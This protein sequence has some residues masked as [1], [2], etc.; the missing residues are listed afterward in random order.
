[1]EDATNVGVKIVESVV[2]FAMTA[3]AVESGTDIGV[4]APIA[5]H[6]IQTQQIEVTDVLGF[7]T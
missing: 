1:V 4:Q 2:V 3:V 7:M 6:S 5:R